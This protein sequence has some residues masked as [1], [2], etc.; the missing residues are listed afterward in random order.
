MLNLIIR[1]LWRK[2]EPFINAE[3]TR[4][5]LLYNKALIRRGQIVYPPPISVDNPK[6]YVADYKEDQGCQ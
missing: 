5:I 4:R 3:I 2:L 6:Y 1:Y